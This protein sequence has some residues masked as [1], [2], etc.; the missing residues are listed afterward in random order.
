[1][2][3]GEALRGPC[4]DDNLSRH[5]LDIEPLL[6]LYVHAYFT[7]LRVATERATRLVAI[8]ICTPATGSPSEVQMGPS[9]TTLVRF[10]H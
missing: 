1:M 5:L 7:T 9:Y 10:L 3:E 2:E 6:A 8:S 4:D